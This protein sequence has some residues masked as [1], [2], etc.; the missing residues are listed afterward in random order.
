MNT[1]EQIKQFA[2]EIAEKLTDKERKSGIN[3][4]FPEAARQMI[5]HKLTKE[6]WTKV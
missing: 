5:I 4:S 6:G 2:A 1:D 3:T